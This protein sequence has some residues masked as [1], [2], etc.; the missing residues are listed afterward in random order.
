MYQ[1]K[2][3]LK[4]VGLMVLTLV[5]AIGFLPTQADASPAHLTKTSI[6]ASVLE[7]EGTKES[8]EIRATVKV[9]KLNL[10]SVAGDRYDTHVIKKM[11]TGQVVTVL[12]RG[13][14]WYYV[15]CGSVKG[16]CLKKYLKIQK[17]DYEDIIAYGKKFL[18]NPYVWG[19]TSLTKGCD[20]SGYTQGVYK[21]FGYKI[22]RTSYYQRSAGIRVHCL[23]EAQPGDLICYYGHV[24][25][26]LGNNRIMHAKGRKYGIV[27]T[28][29]VK[30]RKIASIRRIL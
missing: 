17:K 7:E 2:K 4:K 29:G 21:H 27:I 6:Y 16:Y 18:G 13:T 30:Y 28:K 12:K 1:R 22:P 15:Q 5:M 14:K 24:A 8:K 9:D 26:Y 20:C 25:I 3:G 19:G 11:R 23:K 10:H